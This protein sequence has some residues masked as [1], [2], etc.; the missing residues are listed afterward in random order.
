MRLLAA[1]ATAN[2][3]IRDLRQVARDQ[4]FHHRPYLLALGIV[5][6]INSHLPEAHQGSDTNT[7]NDQGIDFVLGQ[8]IDR[9]HASSLNMT[10]VRNRGDLFD[11]TPFHIHQ[12]E[13]IAVAE[14]ARSHAVQTALFHGWDGYS[15]FLHLH[16]LLKYNHV[17]IPRRFRSSGTAEGGETAANRRTSPQQGE[18]RQISP[19][20]YILNIFQSISRHFLSIFGSHFLF[21]H[22][23]HKGG[24]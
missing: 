19:K 16:I 15:T 14:V 1:T 20:I 22:I 4:I 7:P 23:T 9:D 12:R 3:I 11:F 10:L 13:Y 2:L 6:D 8:E 18:S 24:R 21:V 5:I 17:E